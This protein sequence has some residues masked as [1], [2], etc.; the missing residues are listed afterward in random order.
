MKKKLLSIFIALVLALSLC[1]VT[2]APVAAQDGIMIDGVI[3]AG[4]W[5]DYYLG[6]SVT[7]WS[8]GMAVAV[9]G[10]AD[11]TYLYA[12][13]VADMSQLGWSVG[14]SLCVECNFSYCTPSATEW[15]DQGY[16]LLAAS[17]NPDKWP[18]NVS[19]TDGSDW[20]GLPGSFANHGID[21]YSGDG[22]YNTVP[23]PNVA[24]LKIP[25]SLLTYAGT[26][27]II[28][29]GGQYWQYEY[30]TPFYVT[31]PPPTKADIL[32]GTGVPGRGLDTAPGQQ[33]PFNPNSKAGENAGKK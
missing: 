29:L 7:T 8:G 14:V 25:L 4:E 5:D 30:A 17:G 24:E 15:P 31:L 12:A 23:N 20:V 19:Q 32:S 26:D 3:D 18:W 10:F 16:T 1:L 33:K 21:I 2:A 13:Y 6:T 22:C 9:Y 28:G 11:D 27:D